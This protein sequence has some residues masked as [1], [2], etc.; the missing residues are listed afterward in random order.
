MQDNNTVQDLVWIIPE[1]L[2][3]FLLYLL[4]PIILISDLVNVGILS[5]TGLIYISVSFLLLKN[6]EF[7]GLAEL[8]KIKFKKT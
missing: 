8:K 4:M 5:N 6:I 2:G 3:E 7:D 1:I